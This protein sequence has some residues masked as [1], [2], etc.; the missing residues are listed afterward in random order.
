[1]DLPRPVFLKLTQIRLPLMAIVSILHRISGIILAVATPFLI[2]FLALSLD[3]ANSYQQLVKDFDT[4][5]FKLILVFVVWAFGHHIFAGVRLLL[6]DFSTK[7]VRGRNS[8]LTVLI[9]S[10]VSLVLAVLVV[11]L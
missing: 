8:A 6:I 1:M 5:S 3:S 10:G 11:L 4:F 2:Y 9:L 7:P